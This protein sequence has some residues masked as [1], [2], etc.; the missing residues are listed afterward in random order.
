MVG[1]VCKTM[2]LLDGGVSFAKAKLMFRNP[3]LGSD[4]GA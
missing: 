1:V 3:I 4:I 2:A